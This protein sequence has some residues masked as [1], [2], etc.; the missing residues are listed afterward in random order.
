[1]PDLGRSV[2]HI[3]SN[4]I[5]YDTFVEDIQSVL[6]SLIPKEI[7]VQ[8]REGKW[9]S[10]RIQP[11]RTIENVIEGAVISFIDISEMVQMREALHKANELSRLAI[12]VHDAVDAITVQDLDG[13]ILAWNPGAAAIYGWSEEEALRMNVRDRIAG[14]DQREEISKIKHLSR[15]EIL[16]P[17][18]S[19]RLCKDGSLS[20]VRITATALVNSA[21]EI[22]SIA[23][24][25]RLIPKKEE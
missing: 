25:E 11:Y 5:G 15:S 18:T 3:V 6:N 13:H 4:L 19:Q 17:Y 16:E 9:Y 1:L 20:D 24:T 2:G 8:T 23:T 14:A 22:Y 21:G 7:E 10:M 12:V